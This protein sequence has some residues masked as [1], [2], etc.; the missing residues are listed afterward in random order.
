M[1]SK[2]R[3]SLLL[4][5]LM[6]AAA[7][8]GCGETGGKP[9]D[10]GAVTDTDLISGT[11][12]DTEP[13]GP[14]YLDDVPEL[15]F[16]GAAFRIIETTKSNPKLSVYQAEELG[17]Q[18]NDA[19]YSRNRATEERFHI[20]IPE[21][22]R[23]GPV[24]ISDMLGSLVL[25]GSDECDLVMNALVEGM[26]CLT[27]GCSYDWNRVPYVTT[28][29]PWYTAGLQNTVIAGRLYILLGDLSLSYTAATRMVLFNK[30]KA[31]DYN[32]G[33][34]LYQLVRDGKWTLDR[35]SELSN[36]YNDLNGDGEKDGEDFFGI[37]VKNE[38]A[39]IS[40]FMYGCE[41]PSVILTDDGK[42]FEQVIL[43]E[44]TVELLD[45]LVV[46][47][48]TA[49]GSW[50]GNDL[51]LFSTGHALFS[52][53]TASNV[54]GEEMTAMEDDF[55]VLPMPKWNEDQAEY[56]SVSGNDGDCLEILKTVRNKGFTGAITEAMSALSYES[57]MP[58]YCEVVLENSATRDP[59]SVEMLKLIFN[60]RVMD[61]ELLYAGGG[62]WTNCLPNVVNYPGTTVSYI[63]ERI[64][65][66]DDTYGEV[67]DYI[68]H[69]NDD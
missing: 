5:L 26:K 30:T 59:E 34:D 36:V 9:A 25:S 17:E 38:S 40:A 3:I 39:V 43:S 68:L 37:A 12:A 15:D 46:L 14:K 65:K 1:K 28:T 67:I 21:P 42:D 2:R 55:G 62:G 10:T 63:A 53:L 29:S 44:R 27:G 31:T 49:P 52:V 23:A 24:E 57:V 13:E 11:A 66:M 56:R 7:L 64:D 6:L 41:M 35:L 4:A 32:V 61:F 48:N 51:K 20:T 8:A 22:K 58:V 50:K 16:D 54:T 47:M 18:L 33:V 60:S 45:R 19:V 69:D